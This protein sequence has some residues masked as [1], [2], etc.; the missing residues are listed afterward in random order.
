VELHFDVTDAVHATGVQR[1]RQERAA[2]AKGLMAV[3]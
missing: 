2:A 3:T 1:R